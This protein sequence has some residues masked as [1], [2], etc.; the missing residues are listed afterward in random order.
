MSSE[1]PRYRLVF[2]G[3]FLPGLEPAEVAENLARLFNVSPERV[4]QLLANTPSVIKQDV[5]LDAGNRYLDA[6]AEAGLITHLEALGGHQ[7]A[8]ASAGWDGIERRQ[9]PRRLKNR[10]RRDARR[11]TSIQPDRRSRGGRRKTD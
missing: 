5:D 2:R 9:E 4:S 3:K 8:V 7:E 11:S 1:P 10:D 6:L